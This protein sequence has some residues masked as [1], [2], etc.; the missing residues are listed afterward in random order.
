MRINYKPP[1][2][3]MLQRMAYLSRFLPWLVLVLVGVAAPELR[4]TYAQLPANRRG[5]TIDPS[6]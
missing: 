4:A 1:L 5:S 2:N 3:C 6:C